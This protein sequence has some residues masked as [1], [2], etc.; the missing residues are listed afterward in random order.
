MEGRHAGKSAPD[1]LVWKPGSRFRTDRGRPL[2]ASRLVVSRGGSKP[3]RGAC[4][5][6]QTGPGLGARRR[7]PGQ[8]YAHR[9]RRGI[10]RGTLRAVFIFG[11]RSTQEKIPSVLTPFGMGKRK[12]SCSVVENH[13]ARVHENNGDE[14]NPR[15]SPGTVLSHTL[16]EIDLMIW[17]IITFGIIYLLISKR[18]TSKS[19]I[20]TYFQHIDFFRP[21]SPQTKSKRFI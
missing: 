13:H 14:L 4:A 2:G 15:H 16:D 3:R 7:D 10:S 20:H 9:T 5:P 12:K 1:V 21:I 8:E 6:S 11:G 19:R 17:I 18:D